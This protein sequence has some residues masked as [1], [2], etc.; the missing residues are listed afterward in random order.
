MG[1][2]AVARPELLKEARQELGLNVKAENM[3]WQGSMD[4]SVSRN[5]ARIQDLKAGNSFQIN[6]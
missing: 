3:A 4:D 2:R 5:A 6:V 1:Q